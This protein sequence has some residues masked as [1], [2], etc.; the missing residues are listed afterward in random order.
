MSES[1]LERTAR[2]LDLI[3]YLLEH[4]GASVAELAARFSVTELQITQD[5]NHAAHVRS[6]WLHA[7][8][9][10]RYVL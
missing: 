8:R 4:Q 10:N 1:A 9:I 7:T 5:F 2:A 6:A 3:P